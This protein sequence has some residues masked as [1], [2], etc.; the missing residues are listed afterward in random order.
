MPFTLRQLE[1]FVAAADTGSITEAALGIPV[2]QSSVSAAI[3]QLEAAL[4]VQLFIRH[5]AQ[6]ITPTAE[7]RQFAE[8][9]RSLLHDADELRRFASELTA[10]LRGTLN[11]GCLVTL[12]PLIGPHLGKGFREDHPAVS[13][14]MAEAGQDDL[15]ARLGTGRLSVALTY[16]LALS[17]DIAFTP[18]ARLP[19]YALFAAGHPLAASPSVSLTELAAWPLVLLDLPLSRDYFRSLFTAIGVTP[20]V[21]HRS[22][23]ADVVR[24]MVANDFGYSILNVQPNTDVALDGRRLVSLPIAGDPRPM[25]LGL[26]R[27]RSLRPTRLVETFEQHCRDAVAAGTVP[28]LSGSRDAG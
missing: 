8:R 16:D 2:A 26:A 28:G 11:L 24:T 1:Y 21:A 12:A 6:G 4:G 22:P 25:I 20:T 19:P 17:D 27:L 9:A 7:G 15:M 3:A 23:H 14:E 5:H 13:L 18:L 10:E